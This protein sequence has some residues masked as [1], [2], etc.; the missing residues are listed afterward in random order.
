MNR[1]LP[2]YAAVAVLVIPAWVACAA[3]DPK[4]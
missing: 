3:P 1:E 4:D 2:L